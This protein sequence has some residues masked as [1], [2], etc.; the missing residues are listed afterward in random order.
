ML[1]R[2]PPFEKRPH[3]RAPLS[4]TRKTRPHPANAALQV[5]VASCVQD[6]SRQAYHG[7][8]A[9]AALIDSDRDLLNWLLKETLQD[10]R[11]GGGDYRG[12]GGR[13][14]RA[15]SSSIVGSPPSNRLQMRREMMLSTI[16]C[17]TA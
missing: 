8:P 17:A 7:G 12:A 16:R 11:A 1:G 6:H 5:Y 3:I 2:P 15:L 13:P 10:G 14:R 4:P 9:L